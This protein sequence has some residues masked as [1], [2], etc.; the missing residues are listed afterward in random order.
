MG[1]ALLIGITGAL[2]FVALGVGVIVLGRPPPTLCLGK[3]GLKSPRRN[4]SR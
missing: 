4:N 1:I 3:Q 2:G